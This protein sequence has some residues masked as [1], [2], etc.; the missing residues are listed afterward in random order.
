VAHKICAPLNAF[1]RGEDLRS[2]TDVLRSSIAPSSM[3]ALL[4][5]DS[6]CN[7]LQFR[8]DEFNNHALQGV[9]I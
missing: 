5:G 6:T 2:S 4:V 7:H 1:L 3:G 8:Q 9:N